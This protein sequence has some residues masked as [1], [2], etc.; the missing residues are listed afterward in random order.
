MLE[1]GLVPQL[2]QDLGCGGV[3]RKGPGFIDDLEFDL[4]A[5]GRF[6][7]GSENDVHVSASTAGMVGGN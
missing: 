5:H 6:R 3:G 1:T 2:G 4:D 7:R